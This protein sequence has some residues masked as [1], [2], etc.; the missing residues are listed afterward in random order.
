MT[1]GAAAECT[2]GRGAVE[3]EVCGIGAPWTNHIG[4]SVVREACLQREVRE[5]C[6]VGHALFK[7][8][9]PILIPRHHI[10][11]PVEQTIFPRALA[12]RA[13]YAREHP[14]PIGHPVGPLAVVHFARSIFEDTTT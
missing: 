7:P 8:L 2:R 4:I 11:V 12:R 10:G 14:R 13:V 5:A 6:L 3:A 1:M 9:S